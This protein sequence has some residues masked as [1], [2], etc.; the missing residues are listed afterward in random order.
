MIYK[1]RKKGKE[2]NDPERLIASAELKVPH[3]FS[4]IF[5]PGRKKEISCV[6]LKRPCLNRI[7]TEKYK[8]TIER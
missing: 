5:M 8:T 2:N 6:I 4:A 7:L 1:K 3:N